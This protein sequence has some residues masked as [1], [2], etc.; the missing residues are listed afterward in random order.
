MGFIETKMPKK[1][2]WEYMKCGREVDGT[3]SAKLG[4]C[5]AAKFKKAGG[6]HGGKNA[7]RC[8]WI[9]A[10]TFCRRKKMGTFADKLTGCIECPFYKLVSGEEDQFLLA[11][12]IL[13][14]I[15]GKKRK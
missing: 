5:Q 8:C 13:K 15:D 11:K 3:K 9:V 4:V 7:G 1:N 10:G 2:C 12:E 6:I 14:I